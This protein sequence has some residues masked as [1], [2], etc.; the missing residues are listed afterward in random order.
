MFG[1]LFKRKE[2]NKHVCNFDK[3]IGTF[4]DIYYSQYNNE[5]DT[6][7]VYERWL[8]NCGN[9]KDFRINFRNFRHF[10][11]LERKEYIKK[12]ES[13]GILDIIEFKMLLNKNKN[14]NNLDKIYVAEDNVEPLEVSGN[15]AIVR[16][17]SAG[18]FAGTLVKREGKEVELANARRI[19]SWAGAA[20]LS[21]L[22]MEGTKEPDKC[23]FPCEVAK[24]ILTEAIEIIPCTQKAIDSIKEVK[25]WEK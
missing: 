15:Y 7:Y 14:E 16:T 6:V 5:N 19:W 24:V 13:L 17:Y 22:A 8:C 4:Y 12:L 25:V 1:W 9:F 20:T 3:K 23:K 10:Q 2:T 11:V 18:V 21:Q